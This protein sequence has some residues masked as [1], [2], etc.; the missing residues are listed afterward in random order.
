MS[1]LFRAA[2]FEV[3]GDAKPNSD[4]ELIPTTAAIAAAVIFFILTANSP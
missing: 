3:A 1:A 2:S 4:K